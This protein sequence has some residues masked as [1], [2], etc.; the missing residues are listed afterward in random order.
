MTVVPVIILAVV[1]NFRVRD[2]M[3]DNIVGI[4]KMTAQTQNVPMSS[5]LVVT[6]NP[7]SFIHVANTDEEILLCYPVMKELR[8]HLQDE[9]KFVSMVREMMNQY[10]YQLAYVKAADESLDHDDHTLQE[11]DDELAAENKIDQVVTVAACI[12]FRY[13]CSLANNGK[14]I[15]VDDLGTLTSCRRK[16]YAGMLIDYVIDLGRQDT[17]IHNIVLNSGYT[18]TNAHRLY[19]NKG[20]IL[21]AHHFIKEIRELV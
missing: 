17:D 11:V 6:A 9:S 8:P 2:M 4:K 12:G 7:T 15:Y 14:Y 10:H 13:Q 1:F 18:R 21:Q 19:L 3:T 5:S 16:G 20:F